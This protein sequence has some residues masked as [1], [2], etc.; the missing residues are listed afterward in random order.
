MVC[1]LSLVCFTPN[2]SGTDRGFR[3]QPSTIVSRGS[4]DY[5]FQ[6]ALIDSITPVE[7]DCSPLI[8]FK[9]GVEELLRIWKACALNKGQF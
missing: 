8:A 6:S 3:L 4:T 9:A 2:P 5:V 1:L 7:I